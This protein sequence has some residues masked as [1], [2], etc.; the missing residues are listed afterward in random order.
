M[1]SG[2]MNVPNINMQFE[3]TKNNYRSMRTAKTLVPDARAAVY[4]IINYLRHNADHKIK[5]IVRRNQ[6]LFHVLF[7]FH[8][9]TDTTVSETDLM[10]IKIL[11][12][13]F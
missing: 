12:K 3:E 10:L 9:P 2:K 5:K 1:T 4:C 11:S 8:A 6:V 7:L 13:P